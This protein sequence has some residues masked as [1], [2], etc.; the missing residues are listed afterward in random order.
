MSA[1]KHYGIDTDALAR[2]EL[3]GKDGLAPEIVKAAIQKRI[4]SWGEQIQKV[5]EKLE[6]E[7]L[8][9]KRR[10]KEQAKLEALEGALA[11]EEQSNAKFGIWG[12]TIY[13]AGKCIL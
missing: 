2:R 5:K 6:G 3:L 11:A 12:V 10:A 13:D 9:V 1:K 8:T 7:G 4:V